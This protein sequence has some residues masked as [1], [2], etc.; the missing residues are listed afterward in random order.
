MEAP[1]TD[2]A[3]IEELAAESLI[4][5]PREAPSASGETAPDRAVAPPPLEA[6]HFDLSLEPARTKSTAE[7][8][9]PVGPHEARTLRDKQE[10]QTSERAKLWAE[11]RYRERQKTQTIEESASEPE[12]R[13]PRSTRLLRRTLVV[14]VASLLVARSV[15]EFSC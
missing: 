7:T 12:P 11:M 13:S 2:L 8:S 10:E 14:L 5:R 6:S 4:D 9:R 15:M 1:A 3:K